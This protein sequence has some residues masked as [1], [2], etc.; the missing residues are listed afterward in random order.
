[1]Q[2]LSSANIF[3]LL[4]LGGAPAGVKQMLAGRMIT[5]LEKRVLIRVLDILPPAHQEV[6]L[7]LLDSGSEEDRTLFL[8]QHVPLIQKIIEDEVTKLKHESQ[9][10]GNRFAAA[11]AV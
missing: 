1:M 6:L 7:S 5:L 10:F 2:D 4:G 8:Q 9:Q 3:S 11:G